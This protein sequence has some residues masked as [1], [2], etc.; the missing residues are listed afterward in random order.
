MPY[1]FLRSTD[2]YLTPLSPVHVGCGE[3]YEPMRYVI[4]NGVLYSF[5]PSVVRLPVNLRADLLR[6]AK[7]G[8]VFE[9]AAFFHKNAARFLPAARAAFPVDPAL[10]GSYLAAVTGKAKQNRNYIFRSIYTATGD[11]D[12]LYI[13]GSSVKG[14]VHTA[15]IDRVNNGR[16]G[17]YREGF[18][19]DKNLLGGNFGHSPMHLLKL[20]DFM[21]ERGI[22]RHAA[23]AKR[24]K[25]G[26]DEEGT[27]PCGFEVI[28]A[29]TYR[30][31]KSRWTLTPDPT[32]AVHNAYKT[33]GEIAADLNRKSRPVLD[34]EIGELNRIPGGRAWA[35]SVKSLLASLSTELRSGRMA[36]VRIGKNQGAESVVLSGG[37]AQIQIK[38]GPDR[39]KNKPTASSQ[40]FLKE[41]NAVLPFGW[42]ILEFE[43]ESSTKL[44]QWCA[45]QEKADLIDLS[46]LRQSR[47]AAQEEEKR[48]AAERQAREAAQAAAE[49]LEERRRSAMSAEEL[50]VEDA[51]QKLRKVPGQVNPGT[52]EF[53]AVLDLLAEAESWSVENQR[54]CERVMAPLL[55]QKN[56]YQGKYKK[57]LKTRLRQLRNE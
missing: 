2:V 7:T 53:K 52:A 34:K 5:E 48:A 35:Q 39:K 1:E 54:Y 19:F 24:F 36:L 42:C 57:D 22:P 26:V 25:K 16:D 55:K 46:A 14:A 13:P 51:A 50:R 47:K 11:D 23:V 15:L 29:G 20:T 28:D 21:P 12:S 18:N 33:F 10:A 45:Q 49:A 4:E 30:A 41:R 56:M 43:A 27:L 38:R 9:L 32:N 40:F 17:G 8:D 6:T 44:S 31:F 3:D 37:I